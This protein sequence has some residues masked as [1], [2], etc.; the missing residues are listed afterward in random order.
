MKC[1]KGLALRT[2]RIMMTGE[3]KEDRESSDKSDGVKGTHV[4][5]M[6]GC[7]IL[8]GTNS[9][10]KRPRCSCKNL[11]FTFN[12]L[13]W[14]PPLCGKGRFAPLGLPRPFNWRDLC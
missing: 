14:R 4:S 12:S 13:L 5:W 6:E 2:I 7:L 9:P 1:S 3:R 11:D 8:T 10:P